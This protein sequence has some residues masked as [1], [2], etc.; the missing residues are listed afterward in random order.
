MHSAK[1]C[2]NGCNSPPD[3]PWSNSETFFSNSSRE[4]NDFSIISKSREDSIVLD[5]MSLYNIFGAIAID[6]KTSFSSSLT[7]KLLK[8]LLKS[9]SWVV[10]VDID[11]LL[12]ADTSDAA[13]INGFIASTAKRQRSDLKES[14]SLRSGYLFLSSVFWCWQDLNPCK[15]SIARLIFLARP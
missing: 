11:K 12:A 9:L 7:K 15:S 6:C 2:C 13:L 1:V 5:R 14:Q 8:L 4:L 10:H 3:P